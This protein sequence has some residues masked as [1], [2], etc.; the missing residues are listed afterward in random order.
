[1]SY[2]SS[3]ANDRMAGGTMTATTS[4]RQVSGL[5]V[6]CYTV[7][8]QSDPNNSVDVY[9]G[10]VLVQ[11]IHLLPGQ[12]ITVDTNNLPNFYAITTSGSGLVNWLALGGP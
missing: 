4:M 10:N 11:P 2:S 1:M 12:S 3:R 9:I 8:I 5:N 7:L 6:S